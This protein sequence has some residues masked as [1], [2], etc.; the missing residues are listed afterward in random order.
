MG[1]NALLQDPV[2]QETNTAL[3]A[4]KPVM[5]LHHGL[6]LKTTNGVSLFPRV[7]VSGEGIEGFG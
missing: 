7:I 6:F 2:R 1:S 3:N 4:K 5:R